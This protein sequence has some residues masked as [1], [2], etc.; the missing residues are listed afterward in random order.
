MKKI[1]KLILLGCLV[2]FSFEK[3]HAQLSLATFQ[4]NLSRKIAL[5]YNVNERLWAD[6]KIT[7]PKLLKNAPTAVEFN[8]NYSFFHK[9]DFSIYSGIA[10]SYNTSKDSPDLILPLGLQVRPF[11]NFRQ[12]SFHS[13]IQL[14]YNGG[15]H[16]DTQIINGPPDNTYEFPTLFWGFRYTFRNRNK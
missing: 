7:P 14:G 3:S 16:P 12:L 1:S 4:N 13:E 6:L 11:E 15:D 9:E 2:L 10:V 5:G 8:A